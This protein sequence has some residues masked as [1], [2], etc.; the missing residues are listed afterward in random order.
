MFYKIENGVILRYVEDPNLTEPVFPD[1]VT[2]IGRGAFRD[3]ISLT[4]VTIPDSVTS[5][6]EDAFRDCENLTSVTIPDSVTSI[7]DGAFAGCVSLADN[8][9]FVIV[10]GILWDYDARYGDGHAVIP[11]GVTRIGNGAFS[12][13]RHLASVTI[14]EGVTSIGAWAFHECSLTSVNIPESVKEIGVAAFDGCR[15]LTSVIIPNGVTSIEEAT[16]LCCSSLK[17]V[18]IPDSV[19][20][21]G[22]VA[23]DGCSSLTS[24]ILPNVIS[25]G[26]YAFHGCCS[27]SKLTIPKDATFF[28]NSFSGCS[29]L[30]DAE[31]FLIINGS[32]VEYDGVGGNVIV[33]PGVTRIVAD[34]FQ[35]CSNL[36]SVTIPDSVTS[37][38]EEIVAINFDC[39][40]FSPDTGES[41]DSSMDMHSFLPS[42]PNSSGIVFRASAG[43]YAEKYAKEHG[44]PFEE[45]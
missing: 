35:Y 36:T 23:F 42:L 20:L 45:E 32:L 8:D 10:K 24:V 27:L 15:N 30:M 4:S 11:S 28:Q 31:G 38:G 12:G 13:C 18:V 19:L 37:I 29:K 17:N 44:I 6:G 33:P 43:S 1:G 26:W 39:W 21:I 9:G 2:S 22:E 41:T 14:P 40:H 3:C 25:I 34:S 16:F 5:I 7:G